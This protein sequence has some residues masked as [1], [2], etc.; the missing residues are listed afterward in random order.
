MQRLTA[1]AEQNAASPR[2]TLS[3]ATTPQEVREVQRLR[4]KVFI[5][6]MG[7][8]ALKNKDRLDRDEFDD[9]CDHLIVRDSATLKVVGTYR[10]LSP[11]SAQKYRGFYSEKEFDLT[12]LSNLRD[13]IAEAGRACIHPRYRSGAVIMLLWAGIAGYM[14]KHGCEYLIGCASV[15]LADGG[16]N[17]AALYHAI[18]DSNM[19]PAEYR[20]R[21][22]LAFPIAPPRTDSQPVIPPLIKGYLRSG[23]WI[24]GEPAWDAEFHCADMFMMLPL[25]RLDSRYA[26]HYLKEGEPA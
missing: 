17:A 13:R 23:A 20:V 2:L 12:R 9:Y 21:P 14:Q 19:A 15:S 8:E 11:S 6:G 26:R 16:A 10:V 24:C 22:H 1:S 4:Y 3:I 18:A 5:E 7:L 25:A